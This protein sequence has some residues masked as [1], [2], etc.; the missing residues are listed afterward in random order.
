MDK[1][2]FVPPSIRR[3]VHN[4]T[5]CSYKQMG[6][7]GGGQLAIHDDIIFKVIRGQGQDHRVT[8]YAKTA[9]LKVCLLR[10]SQR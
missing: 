8:K 5:Q 9:D 2:V 6:D 10:H 4:E 3:Y 7:I 1:N